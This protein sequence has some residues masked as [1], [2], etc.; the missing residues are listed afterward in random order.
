[1]HAPTD[2]TAFSP[3]EQAADPTH[4]ATS[5]LVSVWARGR[6]EIT[7]WVWTYPRLRA[8]A[9][10]RFAVGIFL[11]GLGAVILSYG[12]SIAAIPLAG[13]ALVFSIACLDN[14]VARFAPHHT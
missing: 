12:H 13:A 3:Y 5:K 2:N 8:L 1:M 11:V 4:P 9:A 14:A 7:P 6:R 10:V